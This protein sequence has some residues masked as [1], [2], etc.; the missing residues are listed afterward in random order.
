MGETSKRV[1]NAPSL[2][3]YG[4]LEDLTRGS[5]WTRLD[6]WLAGNDGDTDGNPWGIGHKGSS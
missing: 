6:F 5:G 2:V 3:E 1:Y 4:K